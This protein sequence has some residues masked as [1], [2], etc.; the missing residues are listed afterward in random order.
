MGVGSGYNPGSADTSTPWGRLWSRH[1]LVFGSAQPSADGAGGRFCSRFLGGIRH[2]SAQPHA[3]GACG[4]L[5]GR[6]QGGNRRESA[7]PHAHRACGRLCGRIQGGNRR[8]L[9]LGDVPPLHAAL[10]CPPPG[11]SAS[12][13]PR[14]P[15]KVPNR[16]ALLAHRASLEYRF[17]FVRHLAI[18]PVSHC[19]YNTGMRKTQTPSGKSRAVPGPLQVA[20]L[21][22]LRSRCGSRVPPALAVAALLAGRA[23]MGS[24]FRLPSPSQLS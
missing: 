14:S 2:E 21:S 7:L 8:G 19:Q 9:G 10:A 22:P 3:H 24:E 16:L 4:R 11:A 17:P 15:G 12:P 13:A 23:V 6:I 18:P 20:A 1:S 5:C